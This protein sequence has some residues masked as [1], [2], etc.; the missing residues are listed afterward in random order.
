MREHL[1][2][3]S[4]NVITIAGEVMA[5]HSAEITAL[6]VNQ[7]YAQGVD[8]EGEPLREYSF[9]YKTEK[10]RLTGRGDETDLNLTGETQG[11]MELIIEDGA[12][13]FDSP[14]TLPD[15]EKKTTWLN[16]WN[17]AR[18]GASVMILTEENEQKIY[19]IIQEDFE[20][21]CNEELAID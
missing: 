1:E 11:S 16:N 17:E 3:L 12:Y 7:Q 6:L 13:Y 19:P 5:Q 4:A 9:A 14:A 18:G 15:G 20:R 21:R 8:S 10:R 2:S